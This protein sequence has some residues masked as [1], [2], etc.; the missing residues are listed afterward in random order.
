MTRMSFRSTGGIVWVVLFVVLAWRPISSRAGGVAENFWTSTFQPSHLEWL[1]LSLQARRGA[2]TAERPW[3]LEY[4]VDD[5]RRDLKIEARAYSKNGPSIASG[6]RT[7]MPILHDVF[8]DACAG[9]FASADRPPSIR[10]DFV[11]YDGRV[12]SE[13]HFICTLPA[14]SDSPSHGMGDRLQPFETM[15]REV[16]R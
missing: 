5:N 12:A 7:I 11:K 8:S 15:C 14:C 13:R 9:A 1:A 10:L 16:K 4:D 2:A 6:F 3:W